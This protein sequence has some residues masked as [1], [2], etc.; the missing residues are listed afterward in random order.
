MTDADLASDRIIRAQIATT[1]PSD[2]LLTEEGADD[3]ARLTAE[4]V[5]IVDPID[6]TQQFIDRTG[7]F[8]VLIALVVGGRPVVCVMLQP[9]TGLYLAA[10]QGGGAI[11]GFSGTAEQSPALL[12]QPPDVPNISTSIWMGAPESEPHLATFA[13]RLGL[14]SPEV[15]QTGLIARGHLDPDLPILNRRSDRREIL[16]FPQP[17]HGF[18]GIPMR[19]DGSMAWEWDYACADL[20]INEAGGRFTDWHGEYF[21]YNKPRPRNSGGLV[22]ANFPDL[23]ARM[24]DAIAPE[25]DAVTALRGKA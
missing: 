20:V 13:G 1:Y 14:G 19:G 25:I 22:I 4:R 8:D 3:Q 24:L 23:H 17:I 6:G 2:A 15:N 21:T 16:A 12:A 5:W 7:Q 9:T 18:L 10:T 11:A